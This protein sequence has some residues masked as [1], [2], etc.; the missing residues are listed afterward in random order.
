[1]NRKQSAAQLT[2]GAAC[3]LLLAS[4]AGAQQQATAGYET[5]D[6]QQM[7]GAAPQAA[8]MPDVSGIQQ[9]M[10]EQMMQQMAQQMQAASPAAQIQGAAVPAQGGMPTMAA[11]SVGG[12]QAAGMPDVSGIQ[13]KMQEQMMQQMAQQMQ[14]ASPAAQIQQGAAQGG[15]PT[16]AAPSVGGQQAAGMPDVSGIQQKMQEQMM[17]QMAQQMQAASPAAQIQQGAVPAQGGMPTMT[18]PSVGG[19]QAAGMPDVSGIQQKMQEQMMQQMAQQMQAASPAA[20]IQQGAMPQAPPQGIMPPSSQPAQQQMPTN[21]SSMQGQPG[22]FQIDAAMS[23]IKVDPAVQS[24]INQK[25]QKILTQTMKE[26]LS[27][28]TMPKQ[29]SVPPT[30]T[31]G[32]KP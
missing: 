2:I 20:Q 21:P 24:S 27:T 10:Q 8:G 30:T 16:M 9:K 28:A 25:M 7:Q 31:G 17:Q 15:M 19:Q 26:T 14:A 32:A 4:A 22:G 23:S 5:L 3:F 18:A 12:Q 29:F 1:M 11:P 6:G 13:Q